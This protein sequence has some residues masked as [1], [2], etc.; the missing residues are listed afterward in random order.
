MG[1]AV[2]SICSSREE[3]VHAETTDPGSSLS[4]ATACFTHSYGRF[5]RGTGSVLYVPQL[6]KPELQNNAEAFA[7]GPE[8]RTSPDDREF[9]QSWRERLE[10]GGGK[11]RYFTPREVANILGFAPS[12][13]TCDAPA[14]FNLPLDITPQRAWAALGNSIHIGTAAAVLRFA[15]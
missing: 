2:P 3:G 6:T 8:A 4:Q 10:R 11:L 13:A 7:S 15:I 5:A 14:Y 1:I 9:G 12:R